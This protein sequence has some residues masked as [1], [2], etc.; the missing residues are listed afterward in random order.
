MSLKINYIDRYAKVDS[1]SSRGEHLPEIA[2][3]PDE[4]LIHIAGFLK[5]PSL[6]K[7]FGTTCKYWHILSNE[8]TLWQQLTLLNF[9]SRLPNKKLPMPCKTWKET[10]IS[11]HISE[12]KRLKMGSTAQKIT[13]AYTKGFG[14]I[15]P[16]L[17]ITHVSKEMINFN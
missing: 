14:L 6:I 12:R 15:L 13:R 1:C 5:M 3:L 7:S 10:F 9:H 8:K 2:A 11:L 16:N 17:S 4:L